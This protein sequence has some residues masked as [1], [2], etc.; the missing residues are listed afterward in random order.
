[1]KCKHCGAEIS[2]LAIMCPYC[3]SEVEREAPAAPTTVVNNFYGNPAA[4]QQPQQSAAVLCPRCS[5]SQIRFNREGY[6][7][8]SKKKANQIRYRTVGVCQSC[9][10]SFDTD[11]VRVRSAVQ[12][13]PVP[14]QPVYG[15]A[16]QGPVPAQPVYGAAQQGPVLAQPVYG[17]A[18]K[19]SNNTALWVLFFLFLPPIALSVWFVTTPSLKMD[20]KTRAIIVA[21]VWVVL[22]IFGI[23]GSSDSD[24]G[25]TGTELASNSVSE[26]ADRAFDPA[27]ALSEADPTDEAFPSQEN[28]SAD[29]TEEETSSELVVPRR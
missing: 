28:G 12:R 3:N 8:R 26:T 6:E 27:A 23:L 25:M 24:K 1:M 21:A 13:G 2:N 19:K 16:Q 7:V 14:A 9:G 10:Y 15:V 22:F 17:A 18:P 5:G 29:A 4:A 11:K 20:K